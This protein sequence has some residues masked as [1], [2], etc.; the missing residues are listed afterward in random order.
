MS[1]EVDDATTF[2]IGHF[3]GAEF[4]ITGT[5][6]GE[7]ALHRLDLRVLDTQTGQFVG[8]ASERF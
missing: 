7:G 4:I 8:F 2:K 1:G 6:G 5:V 3:A